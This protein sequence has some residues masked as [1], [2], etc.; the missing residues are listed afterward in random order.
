MQARR[1]D[2]EPALRLAQPGFEGALHLEHPPRDCVGFQQLVVAPFEH[3]LAAAAS[4]ARPHVHDMV[5]KLDDFAVVLD[6]EHGVAVV[7]QRAQGFLEQVDVLRVEADARL[8]EN[9]GHVGERRVDVFR[10]L[11]ALRLAARE[12]TSPAREREVAEADLHER[13]E[14]AAKLAL[15]VRGHRVGYR[16]Y[17]FKRLGHG[18]RGD[19]GDVLSVN[20]AAAHTLVDARAAAVGTGEGRH[21]IVEDV[22]EARALLRVYDAAVHARENPLELR[23]L[24]PVRRRVLEPYLRRVEEE[25]ELLGAVVLDFLVEVEKSAV[26]VALPAPE[27]AAEGR[28]MYRVLVVEALVEVHELVDVE[29]RHLAEAVASRAFSGGVV[30]REGVGVADEGPPDASR[31][32]IE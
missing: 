32:R 1:P 13:A 11:D 4:R 21:H 19:V 10:Y 30:E 25:L 29:L 14:P 3:Y 18:H 28:E 15:D 9:V 12:R 8:V 24:G 20:Q 16:I 31:R 26:G 17:E 2:A 27:A 5:G 6:D 22:L 7:A 23:A